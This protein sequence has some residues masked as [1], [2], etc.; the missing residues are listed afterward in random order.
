MFMYKIRSM[1]EMCELEVDGKC[2]VKLLKGIERRM[3]RGLVRQ[4]PSK[5]EGLIWR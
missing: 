4:V 5:A 2:L 1:L 3:P